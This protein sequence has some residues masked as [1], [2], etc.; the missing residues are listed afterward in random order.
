L[1]SIDFIVFVQSIGVIIEPYSVAQPKLLTSFWYFAQLNDDIV[2][3]VFNGE[4]F[5]GLEVLFAAN[6]SAGESSAMV[7]QR[8]KRRE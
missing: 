3:V 6:R 8:N 1:A 7:F 4:S 5:I 2:Y